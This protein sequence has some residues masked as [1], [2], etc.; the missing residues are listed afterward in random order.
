H[1]ETTQMMLEH[2]LEVELRGK[3]VLDMGCG[4]GVLAILA[5][6]RGA[7]PI[8]AV[9]IDHWS[10]LNARENTILNNQAHIHVYEGDVG[11]LKDQKYHL[12]LANINRNILLKDIPAYALHLEENGMLMLSGFYQDDLSQISEI[13]AETGLKYLRKSI[14][15]NWVAAVYRIS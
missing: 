12:I 2:L 10:F 7:S 11:F 15:N 14:K 9:D 8:D 13:C 6:L 4:T 3:S 5:A 1:H